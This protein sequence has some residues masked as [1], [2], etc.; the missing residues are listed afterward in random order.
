MVCVNMLLWFVGFLMPLPFYVG[1]FRWLVFRIGGFATRLWL[2][3]AC[4][5]DLYA[6]RLCLSF[7]GR[8]S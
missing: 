3:V 4:V 8:R 6:R 2:E 1:I 5:N 7:K